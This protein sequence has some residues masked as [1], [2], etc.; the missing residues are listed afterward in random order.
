MKITRL[1]GGNAQFPEEKSIEDVVVLG[2]GEVFCWD[3]GMWQ[4]VGGRFIPLA[5]REEFLTYI[6]SGW[7]DAQ[8][9]HFDLPSLLDLSTFTDYGPQDF[10]P[11]DPKF[12]EKFIARVAE[13]ATRCEKNRQR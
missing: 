9:A 6:S 4:L 11:T 10:I 2:N 8:S 13:V 3:G 7:P 12:I 1:R 5:M